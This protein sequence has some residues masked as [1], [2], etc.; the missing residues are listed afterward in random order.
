MMEKKYDIVSVG[1]MAY[2]MT[3]H[4]VDESVFTRDTTLLD[5]VGTSPGGA[6]MIQ[7][8]TAA[9]LG[10]RTAV[11]G[12]LCGDAFSDELMLVLKD[13]GVDTAYVKRSDTD[14]M[15]LTFALVREDG[16]RHFLGLAGS[17][18]Q[19]LELKD[20]DL[21]AVRQAKIVSYGSFFFLQGLDKG[22]VSE[23]LRTA[24]EAGALTV[25]D[26][27]NDSF[28]Q[29]QDIVLRNLPLIDYFIPSYVEAEYLTGEKEPSKM[30]EILL[31]KGS[32][33]V[34]I[35]LGDEGCY[36]TDGKKAKILPAVR[37]IKVRDT[38]GA[39]DSFVGG[40]MAGLAE[41]MDMWDAAA[42]ANATAAVSVTQPGAL[43][44]LKDRSQVLKLL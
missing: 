1:T 16:N 39:G 40:F 12:K 25:A 34:I 3:L 41:D 32:R 18:N 44:A 36:V 11:I 8:V 5:T 17:N 4:T 19:T 15:S 20:V 7:T 22:G 21:E 42:F 37:G 28:G 23:I 26:C 27:A 29:G 24:K 33:F 9:R 14:T 13:A 38:T 43:T 2:D 30:A 31:K 35:K 6:A 10:C